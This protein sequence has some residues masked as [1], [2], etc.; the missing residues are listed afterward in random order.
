MNY[1]RCEICPNVNTSGNYCRC[2][3]TGRKLPDINSF[4]YWCPI[5]DVKGNEVISE[6]ITLKKLIVEIIGFGI[7]PERAECKADEIIKVVNSHKKTKNGTTQMS[8]EQMGEMIDYAIE[9]NCV[10]VA[11]TYFR[12][13]HSVDEAAKVIKDMR[14][15]ISL[16]KVSDCC[17]AAPEGASEDMLMCTD[18]KEHCDYVYQYEFTAK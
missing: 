12:G 11:V 15:H 3:M 5:N 14:S 2:K 10:D 16:G 13:F 9:L 18:C 1:N 8:Y 7:E 17:G 6:E 4:P